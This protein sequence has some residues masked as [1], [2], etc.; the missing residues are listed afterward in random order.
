MRL[1]VP[2]RLVAALA[3]PLV[4]LLAASW[5][6]R[7]VGAVEAAARVR[8]RERPHVVVCWHEA[9]LPLLWHHRGWGITIVVSAARDGQYLADLAERLGY[10]TV[11]GS[12]RRGA[13]SALRGTLGA[14]REGR[15]VTL[16]PDGPVGPRRVFKGAA[17]AAAQHVGAPILPIH[18]HADR[19]WR[20]RSWDRMVIPKPFA[21][22]EVRYGTPIETAPGAAG[23][24]AAEAATLAALAALGA[25][26]EG[27]WRDDAATRTG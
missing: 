26:A 11:R 24:A 19:A 3:G 2:P 20:L 22:V 14:L 1:A 16:T 17:V 10:G 27:T 21:R 25:P 4:R 13:A 7:E 23:L 8:R 6:V 9:I 15:S 18:A 5:R 12:S